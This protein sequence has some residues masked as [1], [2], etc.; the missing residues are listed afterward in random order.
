MLNAT[1]CKCMI[2]RPPYVRLAD[3]V[4]GFLETW[5]ISQHV[6]TDIPGKCRMTLSKLKVLDKQELG[7]PVGVG[8]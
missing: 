6:L 4:C 1:Q 7:P 8:L 3:D 5:H 2:T